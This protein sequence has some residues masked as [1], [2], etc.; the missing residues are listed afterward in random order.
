[1]RLWRILSPGAARHPLSKEGNTSILFDN[2]S[3]KIYKKF[4]SGKRIKHKE[5]EKEIYIIG[6]MS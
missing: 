5:I 2:F 1:M 3:A 6:I 4:I